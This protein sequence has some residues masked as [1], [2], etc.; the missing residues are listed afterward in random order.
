MK[1]GITGATGQLG[2]IV[3]EQLKGK[4]FSENT[5]AL[6]RN[7]EKASN[8]GVVAREFDYN[9]VDTL[10]KAL[11]DIDVLV[12]ISSNEVGKR[13][14]QHLKVIEAAKKAKVKRI[15]YTSLLHADTT[16]IFLAD[17]HLETE[18]ALKNSGLFYTILRNGWYTENYLGGLS[19]II[20]NGVVLGSSGE[21]KI[22]AV[23]RIDFAEAIVAV[24]VND[25]HENKVYELAGDEAFTMDDFAKVIALQSGKPIVYKDISEDEYASFLVSVGMPEGMAKAFAST[26][27]STLKGDL[28]D[29]GHQLSKLIGRKTTLL[30][31]VV[32]KAL[33][34][35]N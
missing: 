25:G 26:Q 18:A 19:G 4:G 31:D 33:N 34:N 14:E 16:T 8:L 9:K 32:A 30:S 5:V 17:E 24:A 3:I 15:V 21:G 35:S 20:E 29:D 12:L 7:I 6:V 27:I 1:V 22:S 11:I 10:D 2:S 23:P 28:F 13:T